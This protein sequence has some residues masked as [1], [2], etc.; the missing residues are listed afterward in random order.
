M[1]NKRIISFISLLLVLVFAGMLLAS[2][3][4]NSTPAAA[5]TSPS[6]SVSD[7]QALMQAR[8]SVCHSA[9]RVTSAHKTTDQWKTTVDRMIANGAKLSAQEEQ[10]L[11]DYLAANYK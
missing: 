1:K 3:K 10:T 2:C 7:G 4:S 6:V 11:I 5:A 9:N 8:C